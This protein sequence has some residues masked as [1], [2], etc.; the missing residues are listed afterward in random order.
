MP[1]QPLTLY[2]VGHS[3]RPLADFIAL[4]REAGVTRLIDVRSFPRSRTNPQFNIDTL[5]AAL[6]EAGIG[7]RHAPELGGRRGRQRLDGG[8]PNA[9]WRSDSFRNYADYALGGE[10]RAGLDGL[11]GEAAGDRCALMCAETAW[12]RCHRQIITD[13]LLAAGTEVV[14]LI[15]PDRREKAVLNAAAARQPDGTLHYVAVQGTLL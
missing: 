3:T 2:T 15:E 9:F 11:I 6:A 12:Q 1:S 7:Y 13:Y 14:H 8:S 10:F 4:L 5:P